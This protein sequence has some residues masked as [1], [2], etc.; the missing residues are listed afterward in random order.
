MPPECQNANNNISTQQQQVQSCGLGG[1]IGGGIGAVGFLAGP[2]GIITVIGGAALGC[3][4]AATFFP[5]AG[6]QALNA[7]ANGLGPL[8][9]FLKATIALL[10]YVGPIIAFTADAINYE[11]ALFQSAPAIG[12]FLF[13][14]QAITIIWLFYDLAGYF[15]GVGFL[16]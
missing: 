10:S 1:I 4:V 11:I 16:G 7:I 14:L 9:D 8:G 6:S 12:A 13:P 2:V 3:G 15:R 5:Q